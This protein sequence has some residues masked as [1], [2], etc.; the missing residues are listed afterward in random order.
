ML[1]GYRFGSRET[2]IIP[3]KQ[4]KRYNYRTF[5]LEKLSREVEASPGEL[6]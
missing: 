4:G 5:L 6:E 2:K 1:T 3:K